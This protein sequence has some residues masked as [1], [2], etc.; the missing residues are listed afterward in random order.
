MSK[1]NWK[2]S[3][4]WG[5]IDDPTGVLNGRVLVGA[6]GVS[7]ITEDYLIQV[8]GTSTDW[9]KVHYAV[10]MDYAWPN[11]SEFASGTLGLISRASN[12][13]GDPS[14]SYDCYIGQFSENDNTVKIIRRVSDDESILVSATLDQNAVSK[15]PKHTIELRTYGTNP[16]NL[17]LLLDSNIVASVG[18]LNAN[19]LTSGD[20]GILVSSGTVY[21]DNFAV[22]EYTED[23]EAPADW[24]PTDIAGAGVTLMAWYD[25]QQGVTGTTSVSIWD[26]Q[27]GNANVALG[28]NSPQAIGSAINGLTIIRF[29]GSTQY[30]TVT[31]DSTLDIN[32]GDNL[33]I[34]ALIDP[35]FGNT[36]HPL[37][38]K[39]GNYRFGLEDTLGVANKAAAFVGTTNVYSADNSVTNNAAQIVG[40]IS[41]EGFYIDGTAGTT[42]SVTADNPNAAAME[43]GRVPAAVAGTTY[44]FD[45]DVAE[46]VMV[47]GQLGTAERQKLEGYLAQKYAT[48]PR[49]PDSHPYKYVTPTT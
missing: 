17:Q 47:S 33:S 49:L 31:D 37:I 26:D 22:L 12:Y 27:S 23:G 34:F 5:A 45:G 35:T 1:S 24:I 42:T 25:A 46:I 21:L 32:S 10:K 39:A 41:G 20:P 30:F 29:D 28:S 43:I 7:S 13:Q 18:D 6:A 38:S 14:K 48:W 40:I 2:G 9:D 19:R 4:G 15:G 11:T 16:V 44:Y 3:S 36:S 8:V